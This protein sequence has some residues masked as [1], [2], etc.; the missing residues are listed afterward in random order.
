MVDC[1][2]GDG[3]NGGDPADVWLHA[4]TVGG[5]DSSASYPYVSGTTKTVPTNIRNWKKNSKTICDVFLQANPTCN[6]NSSNVAA[7][8]STSKPVTY[9]AEGDVTAYMTVLAS[10]N[11]ISVGIVV[12]DGF[13]HFV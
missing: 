11:I 10:R 12:P 3:C 6:Y 9:L 2:G 7:T 13:Y 8:V 5:A 1:T 4:A